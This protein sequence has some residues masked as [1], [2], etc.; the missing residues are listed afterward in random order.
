M[1]GRARIFIVLCVVLSAAL[2]AQEILRGEVR[3]DLEPVYAFVPDDGSPAVEFPLSRDEALSRAVEEA[4]MMY[5]AMIYGWSFHYDIGEKARGLP[6]DLELVPLGIVNPADPRLSVTDSQ[7]RE[8][9]LYLW[10]DYAMSDSQVQ[11]KAMWKKGMI[12]SAHSYGR[13]P[14]G[15]APTGAGT[16]NTADDS[17][18]LAV[19]KTVLE[20]AARKAIRAIL[21]GN[22]RNRPKEV[23]GFIS[24]SAFPLFWLDKGEWAMSGRFLVNITEIIP[25]AA[26]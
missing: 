1:S 2:P 23:T 15:Y 26:Y 3:I 12:R 22:E 25:F 9:R 14:L 20:D 5:G 6:E 10:S 18:W 4:A 21:Q 11:R 17:A 7:V 24:L 13:G 19:K 8:M 16:E